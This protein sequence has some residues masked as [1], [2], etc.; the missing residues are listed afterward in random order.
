[1]RVGIDCRT[2][3]N[4]DRGEGAGIGHY[5]YYLV[6][7]LLDLNRTTQFVLFF[8]YRMK[9]EGTQEFHRP[10]VKICFF[11]FSSYRK[12]LPF[13]YS[14][15]LTSAALLKERLDL[16]HSPTTSMPLTYPKPVVATVHDLAIFLN[17]GWFPSQV[18]SRRLLV[19]QTLKRAR[20]LIAVSKS[21]KH[22][23]EEL[24]N[25][26][27]RKVSVIYEGV[28]THKFD[29]K[30]KHVDV[31]RKFKLPQ[32]FLLYVGTLEPRK[33]LPGL[34]DAY[35]GLARAK[36]ELLDD[37]PLVFAGAIGY[38]GDDVLEKIRGL[39]LQGRVKYLGYVTHNEKMNL[40]KA[41]T[42]FIFPTFYEGFGLPVLEAMNLGTPVVTSKTSSLPELAG[43]A[44]LL[45]DPSN[46]IA[47]AAGVE[48]I[49][50][51]EDLRAH[52]RRA[53]LQRAKAF[54]WLQAARE[55]HDVYQ[56]VLRDKITREAAKE[57][58]RKP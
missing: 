16:V 53:G 52:L 35:Y 12:F 17:P 50:T 32:R 9:R 3:L 51:D 6:K 56:R 24:F 46:P 40:I 11:P 49:L 43:D 19:P 1:M 38:Q 54:S 26:P 14:H 41:A 29:L 15:M 13:A 18:F 34:I 39:Q 47:L 42:A 4:P 31:R 48:R 21:T 2:I 10:N 30:D 22:D 37:V 45:V 8:D 5:T 25:V 36:P 44:A 27:A 23:L 33:N 20:H 55:T 57:I 58:G 28:D 7:N